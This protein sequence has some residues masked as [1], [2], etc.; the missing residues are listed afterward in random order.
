M[1]RGCKNRISTERERAFW[2]SN[3]RGEQAEQWFC[4]LLDSFYEKNPVAFAGIQFDAAMKLQ[5]MRKE[6]H[7]SSCKGAM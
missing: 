6:N 7:G 5:Q 4:D 3:W 1:A 2:R